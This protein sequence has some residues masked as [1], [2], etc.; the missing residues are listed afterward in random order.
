MPPRPRK[1]LFICLGNICRSPAAEA[2][3]RSLISRRGLESRFEVDSAGTGGWHEGEAADH[4]SRAEGARR[5]HAVDSKARQVRDRD[6]VHHDVIICMDQANHEAMI[7]LGTDEG[8]VRLLL[9]WHPDSHL[10]EVPDPYYGGEDGFVHMYDLIEKACERL[11]D[12]LL[13]SQEEA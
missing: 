6:L 3:F 8:K 4:R 12:D 13:R 2:V 7:E 9:E 1:V 11:L 5:G 10:E